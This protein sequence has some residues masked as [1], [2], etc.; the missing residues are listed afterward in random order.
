MGV[1]AGVV[2]IFVAVAP[3]NVTNFNCSIIL[4]IVS[5]GI[6]KTINTRNRYMAAPVVTV[7][8]KEEQ[9]TTMA[10]DAT[11]GQIPTGACG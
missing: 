10:T 1:L 6:R 7:K 9:G 5:I 8:S 4:P 11:D 2:V 3:P